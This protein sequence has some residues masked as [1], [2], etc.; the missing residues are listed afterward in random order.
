[1]ICVSIIVSV[2]IEPIC[3]FQLEIAAWS[4]LGNR[5]LDGAAHLGASRITSERIKTSYVWQQETSTN[6]RPFEAG[7][8]FMFQEVNSWINDQRGISVL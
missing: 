3:I 4:S 2:Q 1:M 5:Q 6:R 8:S 7:E